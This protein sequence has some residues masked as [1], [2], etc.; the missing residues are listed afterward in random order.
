M[1][2]G[3]PD[4]VDGVIVSMMMLV[5]IGIDWVMT[6]ILIQAALTQIVV[7]GMTVKSLM[8]RCSAAAVIVGV[9]VA[10]DDSIVGV[11]VGAVV[12]RLFVGENMSPTIGENEVVG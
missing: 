4:V 5:G 1:G 11:V 12:R 7:H 10:V 6:R 2:E 3:L 9:A 8:M